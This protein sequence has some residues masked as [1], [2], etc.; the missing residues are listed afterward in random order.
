MTPTLD[1]LAT[2]IDSRSAI[3]GVIGLGYVG[4]PVACTFAQAGFSVIGVDV[5]AR[6]VESINAGTSPIDGSEP[7]LA[8]L[9]AEVVQTGA[10]R[11]T[12]D[13]RDL[14]RADIITINVQTPVGADNRPDYTALEAAAADLGK[15]LRAGMLVIVES[16]VSPGTTQ[17]VVQGRLE[18]HSGLREGKDFFLGACPERVMPGRLLANIR[19]VARVCGGSAPEVAATMKTLYET[20]VGADLDT[21]SIATAELVKV[22]ENAYRDVQIAFANEI[23]LIC[24]DLGEDVWRVRDLINKVP[25]RNMHLP[26]GGVGGHCIPKDPWL[27]AASAKSPLR[28][29]PAAREVNDS[30]PSELGNMAL[31]AANA[32]I[33]A[34]MERRRAFR[35]AILGYAYL[36]ESDDTRNSPSASLVAELQRRG[37]EVLVH[38]PWVPGL[39][40]DLEEAFSTCGIAVTMVHH[41]AY[42]GLDRSVPFHI[43]ARHLAEA[44]RKVNDLWEAADV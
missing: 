15:V 21:A 5:D 1:G 31:Q 17:S 11:A 7:G 12:V 32:L 13:P 30:I 18:K 43:D 3:I 44:A 28:L 2:A 24:R 26:G 14:A 41:G 19:E 33:S 42:A 16:T 35:A 40:I 9:V 38:D 8:D 29:I 6:R 36:P 23:A 34:G 20:I 4:L 27:L 37:F 22:A 25:E 39:Q 10:F